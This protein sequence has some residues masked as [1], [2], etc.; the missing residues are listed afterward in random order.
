MKVN[1]NTSSH[2]CHIDMR[3]PACRWGN[4]WDVRADWVKRGFIFSSALWVACM[5][6]PSGIMN[7]GSFVIG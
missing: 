6:L 3:A 4:M 1:M 2:S 7:W 5:M